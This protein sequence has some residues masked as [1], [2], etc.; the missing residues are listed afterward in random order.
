M[1]KKFIIVIVCVVAVVCVLGLTDNLHYNGFKKAVESIDCDSYIASDDVQ[2]FSALIWC[3]Q[4]FDGEP[5]GS[6]VNENSIQFFA[7]VEDDSFLGYTTE[8]SPVY[9]LSDGGMNRMKISLSPML[10][11]AAF[12]WDPDL[13]GR[14]TVNGGIDGV[15]YVLRYIAFA[16]TSNYA[17]LSATVILTFDSTLVAFEVIIAVLYLLGFVPE[18]ALNI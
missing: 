18:Q 9:Y 1:I 16:I 7:T 10:N 17:L 13:D 14:D 6:V 11:T 15:L 8:S 2:I 5:I 12:L 4:H 3:V